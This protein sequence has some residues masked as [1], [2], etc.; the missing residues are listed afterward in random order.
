MFAKTQNVPGSVPAKGPVRWIESDRRP[1]DRLEL[2]ER[3]DEPVDRADQGTLR[4]R[5]RPDEH[6]AEL[7]RGDERDRDPEESPTRDGRAAGPASHWS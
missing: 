4:A 2:R 1:S 5:E 3:Q 7:A 6:R